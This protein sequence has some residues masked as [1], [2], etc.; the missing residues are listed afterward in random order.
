MIAIMLHPLFEQ[1]SDLTSHEQALAA[2][3]TLFRLS[4]PVAALYLVVTGTLRLVRH[5]PN[6]LEL[7]LQRADPGGILAEASVFSDRYHCDAIAATP[8]MVRAVPRARL[9]A[10]MAQRPELAEAW[11]RH[12]AHEVQKARALAEILSLKTVRERVDA[13]LL[14]SGDGLP[15]R[16]EQRGFAAHIGV[17]PE[18]LYREL[19]RRRAG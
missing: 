11:T 2:G 16:G 15:P 3:E 17:S 12:L 13:W 19:A 8:A 1:L 18:A 10:A 6:G 9:K 4:D 14:L 5:Q 7:T